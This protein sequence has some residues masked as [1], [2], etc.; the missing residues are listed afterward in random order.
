MMNNTNLNTLKSTELKAMAKELKVKNWWN[1]KKEELI[2]EIEKA[3]PAT[4]PVKPQEE[5]P[6]EDNSLTPDEVKVLNKI[7]QMD[8]YDDEDHS[9][10]H[11]DYTYHLR[12]NSHRGATI[13]DSLIRKGY[14]KTTGKGKPSDRITI[15]SKGLKEITE[16]VN[17]EDIVTLKEIIIDLGIK[18]TKARRILRGTDIPRPYN[19]WEWDRE[20]HADII[21]KVKALLSK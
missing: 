11:A 1:L 4:E 12:K 10:L 8:E 5:I 6:T 16:E 18:G 19:R 17:S 2:A 13:L 20:K 21:E 15:T 7:P 14:L 9:I 3:Q